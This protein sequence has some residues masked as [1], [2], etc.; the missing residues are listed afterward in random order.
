M[1]DT[2]YVI[3][4]LILITGLLFTYVRINP[5]VI[6]FGRK[7]YAGRYL[8]LYLCKYLPTDLCEQIFL[9]NKKDTTK[10]GLIGNKTSELV[11]SANEKTSCRYVTL[12]RLNF[13]RI[14][15]LPQFICMPP[16]RG[17]LKLGVEEGGRGLI[18]QYPIT[19]VLSNIDIKF[20]YWLW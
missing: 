13:P 3:T 9:D 19:P 5:E 1:Q 11:K 7:K 12:F 6:S 14:H 8:P 17:V 20:G 18:N 15:F 16:G 4:V 2:R 10:L